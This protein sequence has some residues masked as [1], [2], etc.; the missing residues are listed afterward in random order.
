MCIGAVRDTVNDSQPLAGWYDYTP[1]G[2]DI[3]E[4]LFHEWS[5]HPVLSQRIVESGIW[6]D[7]QT[8]TR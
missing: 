1:D 7:P 4:Q 6:C 5:F 8:P 2:S 3:T